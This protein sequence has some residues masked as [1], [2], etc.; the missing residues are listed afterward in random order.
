MNGHAGLVSIIIP[1]YNRGGLCRKAVDSV[2]AQT[3]RNLEVIVVDDGSVDDTKDIVS[4]LEERVKYVWQ[5][6][7]GV[8]AA[9]NHG[10]DVAQGEFIAFL[11]SDDSWHPWKIEAQLEAFKAFPAAGMVWTDMV[12]VDDSGM[13]KY[14]SYLKRMYPSYRYFNPESDFRE[15]LAVEKV[16]KNC[17]ADWRERRVYAG[18]IFSWMF[19]GNLVHTSTVLL[20]R[21]RQHQ[22]GYFDTSLLKSGEDY[23]FHARTCRFGDVVY[24]DIPSIDYRIGAP[25]QLTARGYMFWMARNNL[26]TVEKMLAEAK[27]Q[28]KLP[29]SM[30]RERLAHALE[31]LGLEEFYLD[32]ADSRRHLWQCITLKPFSANAMLYLALTF[33]PPSLVTFL[34]RVKHAVT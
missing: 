3:Y 5:E 14:P 17:P 24:L 34:K 4:N 31:W 28:L 16:W 22:V 2:L 11:D 15:S 7:A 8:S 20:R 13:V 30:I 9:R 21:S 27:D 26:K 19:M 29:D 12:A 6:N 10:L 18:E 25:D 1:T 33:A 32:R 23:D